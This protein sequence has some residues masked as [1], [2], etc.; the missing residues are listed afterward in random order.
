MPTSPTFRLLLALVA[1]AFLLN[2]CQSAQETAD[3]QTESPEDVAVEPSERPSS[4]EPETSAPLN[5]RAVGEKGMVTA[6]H[7]RAVNAGVEM[8]EKG[9]NAVDA[10]VATAFTVGVVEPMMSGVGGGGSMTL[11]NSESESAE[12]VDF[13]ASA[14]ADPD[15]SLEKIPDSVRTRERRVAIP[16]AVAGLMSAHEKHGTL[17]REVVLEP[18]IRTAREGF[19]VHTLLARVI[20]SEEEKLTY[21]DEAAEIFY[22]DGEPLQAGDQLMQPALANTLERIAEDGQEGF[23]EGPTAD[24]ILETLQEGDSPLTAE[25]FRQYE[26][27]WR[28]PLCGEYGSYTVLAATPPL[29]GVEVLET[30]ELLEPYDLPSLGLPAQNPEALTRL[31]EAIRISR[32]DRGKWLGDPDDT[33]VPAVGLSSPSFADGRRDLI[34]G[35]VPDEMQG[36]DP[37]TAE[38]NTE[39]TSSCQQVGAF[40]PTDLEKPEPVDEKTD[41]EDESQTTHLS[42]VDNDGNAVSLTYTMGLYFGSGAY[43]EGAF[44]NSAAMNFDEEVVAN[45]RAPYRTPRSSTTPTIVLDDEQVQLVVGSPGSGR[46][47]PAIVQM[48]LYTLDY[49]LD[50]TQAVRMPRMYPFVNSPTVRIEDGITGEALSKLRERG[51]DLDVYSP[52]STYFGGVHMIYA[53]DGRLIGV[54]DPRRNGTAGGH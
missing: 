26:A 33:G 29:A 13:Y 20:E 7:P 43:A 39:L 3:P 11:W 6:A 41:D 35:E 14:G 9:G 48:I 25:D 24:S 4:A 21:T 10:A 38:R 53:E 37:W 54:A 22:P 23:Y 15:S 2:G 27:R 16:G 36:G 5:K 8:L 34:G 50:P 17:P 12:F 47:A 44:L 32:A 46:I 49:E 31:V 28:K 30:L 1:G 42:V 51:Y 40:P 45:Q 19:P 18:A 52:Y